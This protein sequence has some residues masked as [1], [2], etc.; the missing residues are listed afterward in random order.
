M[1]HAHVKLFVTVAVC[2]NET[3]ITG[4]FYTKIF[5]LNK[6]KCLAKIVRKFW[7]KKIE[8]IFQFFFDNLLSF[9]DQLDLS[10]SQ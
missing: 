4:T 9:L 1:L 6:K 5:N 8:F 10:L 2:Q 7:N 3:F